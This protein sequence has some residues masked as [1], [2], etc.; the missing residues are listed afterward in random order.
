MIGD[1][2]LIDMD[3]NIKK[4]IFPPSKKKIHYEDLLI[5]N[6]GLYSITKWTDSDAIS[7]LILKN[8]RMKNVTITDGTSG[9]GGNVLSF[10]KFFKY[11]NAVEFSPVH[12]KVLS[13]NINVYGF[14]NVAMINDDYTKIYNTLKQDV[15]F[16][17][18]P[19]GGSD[20]KKKNQIDLF[21]GKYNLIDLVNMILPF[22]KLVVL[23]V[24]YNYNIIGLKQKTGL[25]FKHYQFKKFLILINVI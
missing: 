19:W 18:A 16:L 5:T 11:V 4:K 6:V 10:C 1:E 20:Y 14:D 15:I 13:N 7:K 2:I 8:I 12:Y 23:K 21:M 17:D 9:I 24:P 22:T 3:A 25:K